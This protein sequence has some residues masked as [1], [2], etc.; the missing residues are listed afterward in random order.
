MFFNQK[1]LYDE[2]TIID[3]A[4]YPRLFPAGYGR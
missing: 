1:S 4:P 3:D 2:K